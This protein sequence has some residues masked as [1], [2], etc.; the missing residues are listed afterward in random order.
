MPGLRYKLLNPILRA[1][2]KSEISHQRKVKIPLMND[3]SEKDKQKQYNCL[4]KIKHAL[5]G[6]G[7]ICKILNNICD[8]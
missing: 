2:T 5:R 3:R 8:F 1:M 4:N 7:N 6:N